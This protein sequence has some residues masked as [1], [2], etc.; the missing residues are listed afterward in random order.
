VFFFSG[1]DR[2]SVRLAP[3]SQLV[4]ANRSALQ[5]VDFYR[6][7]FILGNDTVYC[8]DAMAEF[9]PRKFHTNRTYILLRRQSKWQ[10][11]YSN[12]IGGPLSYLIHFCNEFP[13][14]EMAGNC[15][16][17]AQILSMNFV[18]PGIV[19][20]GDIKV[21]PIVIEGKKKNVNRKFEILIISNRAVCRLYSRTWYRI[22]GSGGYL[23]CRHGCK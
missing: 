16:S 22:N 19:D 2:A 21:P 11:Y 3:L 23:Y 5:T 12:S 15:L 18:L 6:D 1:W 7:Q 17:D 13:Y 8:G 9:N 4:R 20:L 10:I 14:L